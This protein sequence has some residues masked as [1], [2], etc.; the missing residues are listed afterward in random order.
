MRRHFDLLPNIVPSKT[1]S[2]ELIVSILQNNGIQ[3]GSLL[4]LGDNSRKF[5]E[6]I[7]ESNDTMIVFLDSTSLDEE[8]KRRSSIASVENAILSRKKGNRFVAAII[9]DYAAQQ[10]SPELRCPLLLSDCILRLE[11]CLLRKYLHTMDS[12]FISEIETNFRSYNERYHRNHEDVS[13]N[14]P[15]EIPPCRHSAYICMITA[16]RTYD[17]FFELLFGEETEQFVIEWLSNTAEQGKPMDE[18]LIQRFGRILNQEIANGRFRFIKRKKFLTFDQS[19]DS[20]IIDD[21]YIY[22]ETAVVEKLAVAQLGLHSVNSLT[23]ALKANECLTINDHHSKCYRFHLQNTNG[24]LYWLYTYGINQKLLTAEN[25]R[26]I[27][28][29]E[30]EKFFLNKFE[31]ES[32]EILPPGI[33]DENSYIGKDISCGNRSND[34]IFVT[35]KSGSG[36]SFCVITMLPS[37]AMLG[38]RMLVF[39]VSRSFTREEILGANAANEDRRPLSENVVNTL[40]DFINIDEGKVKIPVNPLFIGDCTSLPE[41][42]RHVVGFITAAGGKLSKD[43][44]RYVTSLISSMLKKHSALTT[45]PLPLLRETLNSGGKIGQRVCNLISTVLDD[46]KTIGCQEQGWSEFFENSKQIPVISLGAEQ[47]ENVHPLLDVLL[48][49]AFEWQREHQSKS[50]VIALDEI[51]RQSF[52]DGSPLHTIITQGRKFSIKLIGMTQEYVSRDSHAVDIMKEAGIQIFFQPANAKD[53]VAAELGYRD[54]QQACLGSL[55]IGEF[56]VKA[57]LYN[58]LDEVNEPAVI[59]CKTLKFQ[60]SPLFDKY[61]KTN[62]EQVWVPFEKN[63]SASG[64]QKSG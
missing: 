53:K 22:L 21:D 8:K 46:I 33:I 7:A 42:K 26:R 18:E 50:L 31:F 39:D 55:G 49:S 64:T 43:E 20:V 57:D 56:I 52:F 48:A 27:N 63:E 29:A 9:S 1:I 51:K 23:D 13:N 4:T 11:P 45:V 30:Q 38:N 61:M 36:K 3:S 19:T 37:F 47:R 60:D 15:E 35:G 59:A 2:Q 41:K 12:H 34:H 14:V 54:A 10:I 6:H 16:A 25:R 24:D 62:G 5:Q 28:F 40:F 32:A 58:K 17:E 44:I